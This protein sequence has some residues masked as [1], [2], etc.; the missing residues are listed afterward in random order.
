MI[1]CYEL[2]DRQLMETLSHPTNAQSG[3]DSQFWFWC[4]CALCRGSWWWS[5][6]GV[7]TL[8]CSAFAQLCTQQAVMHL[9]IIA[10]MNIFRNYAT[11]AL[12]L[13]QTVGTNHC[14]PGTRT[15]FAVLENC[16]LSSFRCH[17]NLAQILTLANIPCIQ[18]IKFK[19]WLFSC[20][21]ISHPLAGT[22]GMG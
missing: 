13:H 9:F 22:N 1:C 5:G 12:L 2:W 6:V 7:G 10:S 17:L 21:S 16:C 18:H 15:L 11:V 14:I 4:S 19:N 3:V 20:L 8:N